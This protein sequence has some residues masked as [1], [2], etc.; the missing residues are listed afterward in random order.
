MNI[1]CANRPNNY[2][3]WGMF[4]KLS[5]TAGEKGCAQYSYTNDATAMVGIVNIYTEY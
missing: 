5:S 4:S 3:D 2:T 1:Y